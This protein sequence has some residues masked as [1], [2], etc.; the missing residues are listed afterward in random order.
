MELC[1]CQ[2]FYYFYAAGP[3]CTVRGMRCLSLHQ[4]RLFTL[5]GQRCSCSQQCV[6]AVF[7]EALEK[8]E[9]MTGGPFGLQGS[10]H[11]TL[12]QPRERYVRYIVFYFQ[13]LVVSFGGA[14]GLFLGASFISFVEVGYFLIER[15]SRSSPTRT[16][17]DVSVSDIRRRLAQK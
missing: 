12:E 2:P 1:G 8:I 16:A 15:L 14:A 7:K 17:T 5:E 4:H 9:N 13:D 10:V 3:T 6:D 11:Y